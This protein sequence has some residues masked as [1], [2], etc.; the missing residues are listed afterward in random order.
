MQI[1]KYSVAKL[2]IFIFQI[3]YS[4]LRFIIVDEQVNYLKQ[5]VSLRG[6]ILRLFLLS[7]DIENQIRISLV[8][9][10]AVLNNGRKS[11]RYKKIEACDIWAFWWL[12]YLFHFSELSI[13]ETV[14]RNIQ[15]ALA[16]NSLVLSYDIP[17]PLPPPLTLQK[18]IWLLKDS[19]VLFRYQLC[20]VGFKKKWV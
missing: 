9:L 15:F 14:P 2:F 19:V 20:F 11:F 10:I 12:F 7:I 3:F 18:V 5:R 4:I 13:I 8:L 16:Y 1:I 6:F 17:P